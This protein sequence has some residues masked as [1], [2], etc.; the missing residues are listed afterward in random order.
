MGEEFLVNLSDD[1]K[2]SL[3]K[4]SR[5]LS[6][7]SRYSI[8]HKTEISVAFRW[9]HKDRRLDWPEDFTVHDH[10]LALIVNVHSGSKKE[11]DQILQDVK[12]ALE[13]SGSTVKSIE[14]T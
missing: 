1:T 10:D 5:E 2:P 11:K 14:E 4:L 12:F 7:L 13:Q 8:E 3:E 9:S 6:L